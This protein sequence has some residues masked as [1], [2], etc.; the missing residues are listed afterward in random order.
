MHSHARSS[1][2]ADI[3]PKLLGHEA[4]A[5]FRKDVMLQ[6]S[7]DTEAHI[8]AS[9]KIDDEVPER[10]MVEPNRIVRA[11][12]N[13]NYGVQALERSDCCFRAYRRKICQ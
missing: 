5:A 9:A 8:V 7:V 12:R 11:S 4:Q 1:Q 6:W 2:I 13:T 3:L 10:Y